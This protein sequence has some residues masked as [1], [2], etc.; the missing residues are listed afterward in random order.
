MDTGRAGRQFRSVQK[1]QLSKQRPNFPLLN[2]DVKI[3]A[4]DR[5]LR[6][7]IILLVAG[8]YAGRG[9]ANLIA[10]HEI[11]PDL[12]VAV[13]AKAETFIEGPQPPARG[14]TVQSHIAPP[15]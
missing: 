7:S 15:Q 2:G 14:L 12:P 6:C 3:A 9:D 1:S 8:N 5:N 13:M 4:G 11:R 10:G